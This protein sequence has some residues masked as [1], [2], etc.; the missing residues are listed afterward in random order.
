MTMQEP[1]PGGADM[2]RIAILAALWAVFFLGLAF[3]AHADGIIIPRPRP[4]HPVP[5]LRSLAIRYHRVTVAIEDGV[6]T[7]RVDQVF[8]NEGPEDLEGEY[9]F[10]LPEGASVSSFAMWA[11]GRRLEA[12]VLDA[13]E[14]RR[15]YEDIVRQR[16]DPALLEYAG[17]NAFRAR[18]Y[19]IPAHGEKRIELE[20]RE[21]LPREG[22]LVRYRYPLNT[23][24]FSSRPLE[25]A[26][27]I[28]TVRSRSEISAIYS[29]SHEIEVQRSDA[30]TAEVVYREGDV[31]PDRDFV[32][33]YGLGD[34]DL[35]MNLISYKPDGDD[36]YFL[37]LV[38]PPEMANTP[39]I[40][41]RDVIL[42]L[43]VSGSM[44]GE[45]MEQAKG[46]AQY[47]LDQLGP[48]D[49]YNIITF[50]TG[51][52]VLA[53]DLLPASER[54]QGRQFVQA[55][56]AGGG[57]N[58]QRA[59]L[60]ALRLVRP[61][62]PQLIL[63]MTDGLPTEGETRIE[64]I[65]REVQEKAGG[66]GDNASVRIFCFGVG[67]DVNTLLLDRLAQDH[68]GTTVYVRPEEDIE[69]AVSA[70]YDKIASPV[71][72][73]VTLDFGTMRIDETFPYPLPDLFAG[74][75]LALVGRYR[76]PGTADIILA[77]TVN[78]RRVRHIFSEITFRDQGCAD[79]LP[80]LWATRKVG[81]LLTQIRLHG[82]DKEWVDE[83]IVLGTRYGLVTPYTSFLVDDSEDRAAA[84]QAIPTQ[85]ARVPLVPSIGRG[86]EQAD[87]APPSTA[88]AV[89]GKEA[90]EASMAQESLRRANLAPQSEQ[91][92]SVGIKTFVLRDGLWVDT[93]YEARSHEVQRIAFGSSTYFGLLA[94]SPMVGRYLALGPRVLF[95]HGEVA[96][97]I[98]PEGVTAQVSPTPT[99][100]AIPVPTARATPWIWFKTIESWFRAILKE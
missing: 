59:L 98:G 48:E 67:Y 18:I 16:Q 43:D 79:F 25:E 1:L 8:I 65:L 28:V 29:P 69:R 92:R 93:D 14:A 78:G 35:G 24:K 83:V 90:V 20:Y 81:H 88:P 34:G 27:V 85:M 50:S 99:P 2:K 89:V 66:V 60:E 57:T 46:A 37:L 3:M 94:E 97:E 73:D 45:K 49:R 15:I 71:L 51:I 17:R 12:Q 44:R 70:F 21:I 91:V 72:T 56:Q 74:E 42:V 33:Y 55:L 100:T 23:E 4:G 96:Y 38:S 84:P 54:H 10:P 39:E 13:D 31:L 76:Q 30:K 86:D 95:V 68:G 26:S 7:T 9:L 6:A 5:P 36:G 41:A 40:V 62:R 77:G 19:P 32:L 47:L 53:P 75:Q 52:R 63:F 11:D 61:E 80:R 87:Q 22:D 82:A 64:Q 58:I